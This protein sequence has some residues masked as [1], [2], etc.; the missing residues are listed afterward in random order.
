MHKEELCMTKDESASSPNIP[1]QGA[2]TLPIALYELNGVI[3]ELYQG[4]QPRQSVTICWQ[5][6]KSATITRGGDGAFNVQ[7]RH[8]ERHSFSSNNTEGA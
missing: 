7:I 6:L 4:G 5:R 2:I 3:Y 8:G 1:S